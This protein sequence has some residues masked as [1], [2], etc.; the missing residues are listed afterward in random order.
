MSIRIM[1]LVWDNFPIGGSQ[2]LVMLAM[3]DWC[4][5]QGESLFPSNEKVACKCNMSERQ[6]IRIINQLTDDGYLQ[7][8]AHADGGRSICK[9]Y[10]IDLDRL[11]GLAEKGDILSPQNNPQKLSTKGDILSER[12]TSCHPERVTSETLKGDTHV[13]PYSRLSTSEPS[14]NRERDARARASSVDNSL[15]L[16]SEKQKNGTALPYDWDLSEDQGRW[17]EK[18]FNW[19]SAKVLEVADKFK[20]WFIAKPGPR[21]LSLDWNAE[22]RNWCRKEKS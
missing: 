4:N 21:G 20:D 13:T 16:S 5:D 19:S 7:V 10:R 2:K 14:V 1:T 22:W 11:L 9:D 12:V 3:A 18:E 6:V 15:S 8:V 17:A